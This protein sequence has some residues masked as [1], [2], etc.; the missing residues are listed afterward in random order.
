MDI[1]QSHERMKGQVP[2]KLK[3]QSVAEQ[4]REGKSPAERRGFPR[5]ITTLP[6]ELLQNHVKG[7]ILNL[8]ETGVCFEV[9]GPVPSRE[10]EFLLSINFSPFYPKP[11]QFPIGIVWRSP[12]VGN[13][14]RIGAR[15]ST[16]SGASVSL[17]RD[18][19]FDAYAEKASAHIKDDVNLKAKVHDF[20]RKDVRQYHE[21]LSALALE[22]GNQE[23]EQPEIEKKL[24]GL[25]SNLLM[26]AG[27]LEKDVDA[28]SMKKIKQIF[29]E[30]IGSS[31][32]QGHLV[33]MAYEKPRGYPGDYILFEAIYE[34]R[35]KSEGIGRYLD[36]CFLSE[37]YTI[38][39]RNRKDKMKVILKDF[40]ENS[41]LSYIRLL[42]VA[43]GPCREVRELFSEPL[44]LNE[45]RVTFTGLDHD[46]E[47]LDLSRMLL[48][49][50]PPNVEARFF[51]ENVLSLF[52]NS[53]YYVDL[54]GKQD[55]IY[56]LGL[57]EYLPDRIFKKLVH[58][59][60]QL[61]NEKGMLVITYKDKNIPFPALPPDWFCDWTFVK[62][63]EEDLMNMAKELGEGRYSLRIERE[64]TG[65]IFFLILTKILSETDTTPLCADLVDSQQ[66]I[67]PPESTL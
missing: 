3:E 33:K 26:K 62:R 28:I 13:K 20:F 43:C 21:D 31:V 4:K 23:D 61:L 51:K 49:H 57:S 58:F 17:V 39:V 16:S 29:R 56:I 34:N 63:T 54:L 22:I 6:V 44:R 42:N 53:K 45:K 35:P 10:E 67:S 52:R 37:S 60:F 47:A 15:F 1:V 8:G 66:V 48:N 11:I 12:H 30:L 19:L 14:V 59:L 2:V 5:I 32:Y 64:G 24:T 40:I 38:A 65:C 25:T 50:L 46:E 27:S 55:V 7:N 18:F 36:R 9:E 41:Q